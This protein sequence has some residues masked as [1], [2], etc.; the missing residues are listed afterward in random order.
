[1]KFKKSECVLLEIYLWIE[2]I[3]SIGDRNHITTAVLHVG[4]K[5][6]FSLEII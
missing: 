3:G 1:M 4:S 6:H 2:E 5:L